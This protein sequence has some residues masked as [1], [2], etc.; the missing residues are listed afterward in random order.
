VPASIDWTLKL[1][2]SSGG[3]QLLSGVSLVEAIDSL[4]IPVSAGATDLSVDLQPGGAGQVQFL[5]I[6]ATS[7]G[8]GLTFKVNGSG[9]PSHA[10]ND[11]LVLTGAGAVELLGFPPNQLLFSNSLASAVTVSILVGR[12]AT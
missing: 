9:N 11:A 6:N 10:L 5:L 7:Y 1:G 12:L 4:E 2:T 3:S 8:D